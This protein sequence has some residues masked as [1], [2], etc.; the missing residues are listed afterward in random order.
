M[1]KM[2][3][4]LIEFILSM[5]SQLCTIY[6]LT[7]TIKQIQKRKS[8]NLPYTY[9]FGLLIFGLIN[10]PIWTY[11]RIYFLILTSV[12][13][14]IIENIISEFE[15]EHSCLGDWDPDS[16][17]AR[18]KNSSVFENE[19]QL[20]SAAGFF[21]DFSFLEWSFIWKRSCLK[22]SLLII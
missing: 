22:Q 12:Y 8:K 18:F 7:L 16:P 6:L 13:P 9:E 17:R 10:I 20:G 15:V 14:L 19:Q 1:I 11:D 3:Y 4:Y 5:I 2:A 21:W